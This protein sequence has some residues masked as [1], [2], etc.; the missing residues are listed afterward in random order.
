M[1][2]FAKQ[3]NQKREKTSV[4]QIVHPTM[5]FPEKHILSACFKMSHQCPAMSA[6]QTN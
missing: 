5:F 4:L 2:I 1:P 6:K 3:F